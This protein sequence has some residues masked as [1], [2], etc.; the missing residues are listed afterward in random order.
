MPERIGALAATASDAIP[1]EQRRILPP[2]LRRAGQL[3]GLGHG[4]TVL[5][6]ALVAPRNA[7]E[8][9]REFESPPLRY[10]DA[11]LPVSSVFFVTQ[12]STASPACSGHQPSRPKACGAFGRLGWLGAG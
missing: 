10:D 2:I 7:W 8:C 11:E 12:I 6:V 1:Y 4:C 5:A 3:R 9:Q